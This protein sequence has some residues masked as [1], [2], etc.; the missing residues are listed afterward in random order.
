MSNFCTDIFITQ[1]VSNLLLT[2]C[3]NVPPM[4]VTEKGQI[5]LEH[6]HLE[7]ARSTPV[8][9]W[10]LQLTSVEI[11]Q[12]TIS[13][14]E[15]HCSRWDS[16]DLTNKIMCAHYSWTIKFMKQKVLCFEMEKQFCTYLLPLFIK[17]N[18]DKLLIFQQDSQHFYKFLMTYL[19]ISIYS[20][21]AKP[22]MYDSSA[23]D[24]VNTETCVAQWI[25]KWTWKSRGHWFNSHPPSG[26]MFISLK[27]Q[28]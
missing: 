8:R 18:I 28:I 23:W 26:N 3:W 5:S 1:N 15:F 20:I 11:I 17:Y 13:T 6:L 14:Q 24:K 27:Y 10:K 4:S 2:C 12:Q 7:F 21:K 19:V 16:N 9:P 25:E 22:V